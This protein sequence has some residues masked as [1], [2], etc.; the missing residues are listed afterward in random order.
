MFAFSRKKSDLI[1][2]PPI[3]LKFLVNGTLFKLMTL[4]REQISLVYYFREKII[5]R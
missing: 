3:V 5:T 1:F 2:G 4:S